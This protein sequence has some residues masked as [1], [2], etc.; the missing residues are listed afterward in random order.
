MVPML[1]N[2]V[3]TE[4]TQKMLTYLL[5]IPVVKVWTQVI[6]NRF[7]I[8]T[9]VWQDIWKSHGMKN[10][11][12]QGTAGYPAIL[13]PLYPKSHKYLLPPNYSSS[14]CSHNFPTTENQHTTLENKHLSPKIS[15]EIQEFIHYHLN[16]FSFTCFISWK[17]SVPW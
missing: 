7:L 5:H 11:S 6:I 8:Y 13:G 10:F 15:W 2:S 14:Q 12:M 17:C 16:R 3:Y 4:A 9:T 1:E